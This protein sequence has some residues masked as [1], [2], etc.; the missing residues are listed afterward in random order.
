M[1]LIQHPLARQLSEAWFDAH[2]GFS[3]WALLQAL[4]PAS[5]VYATAMRAHA[6]AYD[7]GV[8]PIVRAPIPVVSVGNLIAGGA[9]KTP[10]VIEL[11]RRL[12]ALGHRPAVLSRGYGAD[13]NDA[14]L[15]ADA[16]GIHLECAA[17]GDEPLLIARRCEGRTVLAGPDRAELAALAATQH[18]ATLAILDDGMQH[19]RLHRDLEI[20]VIDASAPLG[21]GRALPG[22]PL[23]EPVSALDRAD[24]VWLSR[25]DEVGGRPVTTGAQLDTLLARLGLPVVRACYRIDGVTELGGADRQAGSWLSDKAVHA[26]SGVARPRSFLQTLTSAGAR[27]CGHSVFGDHHAFTEA[28]VLEVLERARAQ[29]ALVVTTEKDAQRLEMLVAGVPGVGAIRVVGV[30]T[31]ILEGESLLETALKGLRHPQPTA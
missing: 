10:V 8:L 26:L 29:G 1:T 12:A 19:R 16:E 28:E 24:L 14:R 5:W 23:R 9:G 13:R 18:G 20:V 25:T 4:A 21:N 7:H 3:K 6:L 22:G 2:P 15:V 31:E 17:A 30:A 11:S 27:V